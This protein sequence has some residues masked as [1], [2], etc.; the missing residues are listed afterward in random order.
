M[1]RQLKCLG[2]HVTEAGL[3][4]R[5]VCWCY[6]LVDRFYFIF[7]LS[8][9]FKQITLVKQTDIGGQN[10]PPQLPNRT[11]GQ[12][13]GKRLGPEKD[14]SSC[15]AK[16][17]KKKPFHRPEEVPRSCQRSW[18]SLARPGLRVWAQVASTN[19]ENWCSHVQCMQIGL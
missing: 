14:R 1:A 17:E 6:C 3:P 4:A 15:L 18:P 13:E 9:T 2:W 7:Y 5:L 11:L 10:S 16:R 8:V 12:Q 19:E